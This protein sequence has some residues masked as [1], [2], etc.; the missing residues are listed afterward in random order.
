M[1][2]RRSIK[3]ALRN[4]LGTLTSRYSDFDGYWVLGMVIADLSAATVDLIS[5]SN[6]VTD[7]APMAA[8]ILLARQR[9]HEQVA[10]QRL[11]A[12]FIGSARLEITRSPVQAE[13]N[14]NGHVARGYEVTFAAHVESDL[15]RTYTSKMSVFVAPHDAAIE[16]RSVRREGH[17][18]QGG[19]SKP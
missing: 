4:Y 8:F 3:G 11:P 6:D 5:D 12:S 15:H 9:F 13:G 16:T 14:V 1:T 7:S 10:K 17:E 18:K 2:R 19:T